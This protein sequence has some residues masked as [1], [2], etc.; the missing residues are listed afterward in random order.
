M[1]HHVLQNNL[2][3]ETTLVT[4]DERGFLF[5]VALEMGELI[6]AGDDFSVDFQ[7]DISLSKA[8]AVGCT[9]VP[10]EADLWSVVDINEGNAELLIADFYAVRP[11]IRLESH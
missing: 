3:V 9:L 7:D 6:I 10:D 1:I 11:V 4:D 2:F 5:F 8:I